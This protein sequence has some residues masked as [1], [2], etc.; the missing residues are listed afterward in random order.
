MP[1]V[2]RQKE[3]LHTKQPV[4]CFVEYVRL[5]SDIL[6]IEGSEN[7]RWAKETEHWGKRLDW[8]RGR[9]SSGYDSTS[10]FGVE[11]CWK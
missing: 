3:V 7:I 10:S 9:R 6:T 11:Y 5:I 1:Q 8:R 4:E 2:A